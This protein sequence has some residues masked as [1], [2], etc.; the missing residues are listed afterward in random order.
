MSET[1]TK[2]GLFTR[3]ERGV[4]QYC[5]DPLVFAIFLSL[6]MLTLA[7]GLTD[8][9]PAEAISSWGNGLTACWRSPCKCA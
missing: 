3:F 8:T 5:P 1:T 9:Q 6:V 4:E 7:L 2:T